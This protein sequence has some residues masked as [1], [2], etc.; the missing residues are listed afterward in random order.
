MRVIAFG[1]CMIEV[2]GELGS[3][4]ARLGCAGDSYNSAVYLARLGH[5]VAYASAL[6]GDRWSAQM[7]RAWAAEGIDTAH[8][9]TVAG[10][11]PG[12]YAIHT[13]SAGERSFSY[14]RQ[15]SAARHF[16]AQ[17][18]ADAV[19]AAIAECDLFYC[20]GITLSLFDADD[21]TRMFKAASAARAR[22]AIV[23]FDPNYRPAGW[24]NANEAANAMMDFAPAISIILP[25]F[26]DEQALFGDT[27]P[28]AT[29][30]RWQA[31]GI[32]EIVV[33]CGAADVQ[34]CA[35]GESGSV[36]VEP[37]AAVDTTGAGDSFNAG[38]LHGRMQGLDPAQAIAK[39]AALAAQVVQ[40]PG[41]IMPRAAF[42]LAMKD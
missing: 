34:F 8:V 28:Q 35:G 25:S 10:K 17:K 21:R 39:G 42:D 13:D 16:F 9:L 4:A 12:L 32:G 40:Y 29:L 14:W 31:A 3:A 27:D 23:A 30:R 1:E 19:L 24:A 6:G 2:R 11:Q 33:K 5:A 7:R 36:A 41:A 38:Y 22:G 18:G 26:D 20:S 37:V 15:D